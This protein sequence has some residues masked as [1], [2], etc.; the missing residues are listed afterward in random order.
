[1]AF[2]MDTAADTLSKTMDAL[3]S[4]WDTLP[5]PTRVAVQQSIMTCGPKIAAANSFNASSAIVELLDAF[6]AQKAD[7]ARCGSRTSCRPARA[8]APALARLS[9]HR[10][11]CDAFEAAR[12]S[13]QDRRFSLLQGSAGDGR[14]GCPAGRARTRIDSSLTSALRGKS[15][16][17]PSREAAIRRPSCGRLRRSWAAIRPSRRCWTAQRP[18]SG[19]FPSFYR[20]ASVAA[21]RISGRAPPPPGAPVVCPSRPAA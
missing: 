3:S 10:A 1:M 16:M 2:R 21:K 13:G 6:W 8:P 19:L 20:G 5:Q 7:A 9:T 12:S 11:G 15:S 14:G 17:M 18:S 4:A